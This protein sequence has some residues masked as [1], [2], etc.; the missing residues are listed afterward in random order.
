MPVSWR[1]GQYTM[2]EVLSPDSDFWQ[3][4]QVTATTAGGNAVPWSTKKNI[5]Q[6]LLLVRSTDEE[7]KLLNED[8]KHTISY[9]RKRLWSPS[10]VNYMCGLLYTVDMV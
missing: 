4:M 6:A 7:K 5:M 10:R 9:W 1:V 3:E 8:M 2:A